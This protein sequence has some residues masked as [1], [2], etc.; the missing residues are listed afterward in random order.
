MR[1]SD[2]LD[3]HG[4]PHDS[5]LISSGYCIQVLYPKSPLLRLPIPPTDQAQMHRLQP[6]D[7]SGPMG[8][9]IH[10][11]RRR[12]R[13]GTT[14]TSTF[15]PPR[16]TLMIQFISVHF[17]FPVGIHPGYD[18]YTDSRSLLSFEQRPYTEPIGTCNGYSLAT[19]C[20]G[21]NLP[22][23]FLNLTHGFCWP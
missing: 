9:W 12:D 19:R 23:G 5:S 3:G 7:L 21:G 13:T 11:A 20:H 4:M 10:P 22:V 18:S 15:S 17:L 8:L 6:L 2:I 14:S 1:E 16:I